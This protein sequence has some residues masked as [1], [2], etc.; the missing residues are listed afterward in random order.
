MIQVLNVIALWVVWWCAAAALVGGREVRNWSSLILGIGLI[1]VAVSA[2]IGA[3]TLYVQPRSIRWWASGF[4]YGVAIVSA[5]L[6]DHR[7][8][9]EKQVRMLLAWVRSVAV[10]IRSL[11]SRRPA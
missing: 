3:I 1:F 11:A 5:W 8:G 10:R 4:I 9:I 2:F 7:F 6:Y